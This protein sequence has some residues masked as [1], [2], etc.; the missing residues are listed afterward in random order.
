MITTTGR[1]Q[2]THYAH[3]AAAH[4]KCHHAESATRMPVSCNAHCWLTHIGYHSL[5][6][7]QPALGAVCTLC[8]SLRSFPVPRQELPECLTECPMLA[9]THSMTVTVTAVPAA[10]HTDFADASDHLECHVSNWLPHKVTGWQCKLS[11]PEVQ[12]HCCF[13]CLKCV[14]QRC[15]SWQHRQPLG[16]TA[17]D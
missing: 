4:P 15:Q 13:G 17:C 8:S 16:G 11:C 9:P 12:R 1:V 14:S 7:V 6:W 3:H 5:H 10:M 2:C